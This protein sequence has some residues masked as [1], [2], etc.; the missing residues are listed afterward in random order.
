VARTT[1]AYSILGQNAVL[2]LP[3]ATNADASNGMN[4]PVPKVSSP[5]AADSID[6]LLLYVVNGDSADH[7]C[8]VRSA[9]G[10]PVGTRGGSGDLVSTISHTAGGGWIGPLDATRFAQSDGSVNVDFSAATSMTITA[11]MIPARW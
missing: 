3:S 4:I 6:R 7:T 1:L 8:T 2:N 5:G 10:S 11:Y 9:T